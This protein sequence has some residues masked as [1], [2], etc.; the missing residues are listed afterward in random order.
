MRYYIHCILLSAE[1]GYLTSKPSHVTVE[2]GSNVSLSCHSDTQQVHWR[3][4]STHDKSTSESVLY[5]SGHWSVDHN[6]TLHLYSVSSLDTGTY[7]C[8]DADE[9]AFA[10]LHVLG[11]Y[12]TGL[13][14]VQSF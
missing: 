10:E 4:S 14:N 13:S 3:L 12:V 6:G 11:E 9:A 8:E 2:R 5:G 7:R 1:H